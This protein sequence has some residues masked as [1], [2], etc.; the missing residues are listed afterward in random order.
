M[1]EGAPIAL[2]KGVSSDE[3]GAVMEVVSNVCC[4][5]RYTATTTSK[6]STYTDKTRTYTDTQTWWDALRSY[7]FDQSW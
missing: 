5:A 3:L 1:V 6:T 7:A 2:Q 4:R